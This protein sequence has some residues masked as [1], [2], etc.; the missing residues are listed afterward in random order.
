M[1]DHT[2]IVFDCD[3]TLLDSQDLI[4]QAMSEAFVREG[5]PAPLRQTTL[6]IVGLSLIEAMQVIVPDAANEDHTRLATTYRHVF[7]EIIADSSR[8]EPLYDG[9]EETVRYLAGRDDVVLGIATGKSQRGV[10]RV[11]TQHDLEQCFVT[12]QTADDA[13]SKPHPGMLHQAMQEAGA[14]PHN[15]IMIGDT[16]YDLEMANA[17]G[18]RGIG[19][20]WG[21]HPQEHLAPL[22]KVEIMRDFSALSQFLQIIV[23]EGRSG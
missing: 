6:S 9:A 2:L 15:T 19:V 10:R 7:G 3:G 21:Y 17:A 14:E 1:A 13:P 12:V 8:K 18:A 22:S 5:L 11:L 4:V 16:T 20:S 23:S